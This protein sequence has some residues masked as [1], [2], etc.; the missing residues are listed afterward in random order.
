MVKL[1]DQTY[2]ADILEKTFH[3]LRTAFIR[4]HKKIVA[5]QD[6]NKKKWKFYEKLEFLKEEIDKP[7]KPQLNVDERGLLTFLS[8]THHC[9]TTTQ[10]TILIEICVTLF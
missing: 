10:L 8:H 5:G 9:G 6:P 1:F 4:E 7:K 3:T 2:S